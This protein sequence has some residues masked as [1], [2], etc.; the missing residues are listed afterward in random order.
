MTLLGQRVGPTF[1]VTATETPPPTGYR[2]GAEGPIVSGAGA[3]QMLRDRDGGPELSGVRTLPVADISV[4]YSPRETKV[5]GGHVAVLMEVV[6]HLPPVIVDRR[7]MT[8]I[9]GIHRLEAFRLAGR[10]HIKA[11]MFNGKG[12]EAMVLAIQANV[13]HG[14]PLSRGERR[15][16]ARSLLYAFPERSDRWMG[17]VCGLSH[18]TIALIR[19]SLC[20][21]DSRVRTGRDGRRRPV[22]RRAGQIA[23]A[24]V[25][26]DNPT[27][28]VR[29]AAGVA[30][31]APSTVHRA[32]ARLYR[33]ENPSPA[34]G[35]S[36]APRTQDPHEVSDREVVLA[37]FPELDEAASW[38]ART[39]VSIEDLRT[40]LGKLPLSAV[41]TVVDECRRRAQIWGEI[42]AAVEGRARGR[43]P[44]NRRP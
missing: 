44:S 32:R 19:K 15:V 3:E 28:S 31:V 7:T 39:T 10:S 29:R 35:P 16:A 26:A 27:A 20:I 38:L 25:I 36:S 33:G 43:A 2:H 41:Y 40:Y 17:E 11:L 37:T 4:G 34:P 9:D 21:A 22:D 14:K 30:G 12:T 5:D 13:K 6:D 18:T 1:T 8:V 23:V 24:R 42:A